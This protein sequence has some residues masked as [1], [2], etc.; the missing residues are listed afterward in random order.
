MVFQTLCPD[1]YAVRAAAKLDF[2][3]FVQQELVF[4]KEAG[5]PPFAATAGMEARSLRA[6]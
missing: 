2:E 3:S 4:R 1:N 5:Y 6:A